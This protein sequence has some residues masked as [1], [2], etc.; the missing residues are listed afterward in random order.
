M[1]EPDW[2]SPDDLT[3]MHEMVHQ[4]HTLTTPFLFRYWED[5]RHLVSEFRRWLAA[6]PRPDE[7]IGELRQ[8]LDEMDHDLNHEWGADPTDGIGISARQLIEGVA[9]V[10]PLRP[11]AT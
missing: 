1:S 10:E 6:D 7:V 3:L 4:I 11:M 2:P 9:S 5:Y 8:T